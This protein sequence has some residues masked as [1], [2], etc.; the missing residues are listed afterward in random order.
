MSIN[1]PK[2]L[3]TSMEGGAVGLVLL[4]W[5]LGVHQCAP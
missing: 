3:E 5:V 2:C 1:G 4:A